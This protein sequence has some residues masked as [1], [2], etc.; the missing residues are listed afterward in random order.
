MKFYETHYD[1]YLNA[2]EK[3]NFH[4]NNLQIY[5]QIPLD[6]KNVSNLIFYGPS[7]VG[8]YSQVLYF[9]KRYS[10]SQLKY[11]KKIEFETE[12][13]KYN[14][15]ISDIHY[16]IDM[17]LLGCNSK[18][19]WHEI[20]SHIID[21]ISNNM[22]TEKIGFVVCKNFHAIH[23]ELLEI[24]YSYIQQYKST[25]TSQILIRFIIITENVSFLP[26]NII[27]CCQ[28]ISVPRP[29]TEQY[30][31]ILSCHTD[32]NTIENRESNKIMHS[33]KNE[34]II[35]IK[36]IK[37]FHL[38]KDESELP[39]DAFIFICNQIIQEIMNPDKIVYAVFRDKLYDILVYN[40][41]AVECLWY[42]LSYII[43]NP[44][45]KCQLSD[46]DI[47][48]ILDKIHIFLKYYNNNYRPIY[49]L[50]SIFFSIISKIHE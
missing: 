1:E 15:K 36:E 37:S 17:S 40:L 22:N 30:L 29:S 48:E 32:E 12:K 33:I 44:T 34:Q 21:I 20:F 27:Q 18:I 4:P 24:F 7:G 38:L 39:M 50:E 23:N 5:S 42:I 13:K 11:E 41:D 16:E 2:V 6:I 43:C 35:N 28:I 9:L 19:L 49:H 25:I 14:Y 8:K 45:D 26:N 3:Y 10:P 31:Q 47:L 46:K